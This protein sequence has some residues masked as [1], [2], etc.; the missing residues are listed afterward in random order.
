MGDIS[1]GVANT[2]WQAKNVQKEKNSHD[3]QA[4]KL[5]APKNISNIHRTN[6]KESRF[7]VHRFFFLNARCD[8]LF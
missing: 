7:Q 4:E 6:L 5:A 8:I 3:L 2:L 1:K